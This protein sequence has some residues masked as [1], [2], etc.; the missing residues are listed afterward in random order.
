MVGDM[1]EVMVS[2]LTVTKPLG[3][4]EED[5]EVKTIGGGVVWDMMNEVFILIEEEVSVSSHGA[6]RVCVGSV[7]TTGTLTVTGT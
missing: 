3:I 1:L 2:N 4:V 7:T 6:K 5:C